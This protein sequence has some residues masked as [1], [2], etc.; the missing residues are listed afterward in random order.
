MDKAGLISHNVFFS[1]KDKSPEAQAHL[2]AA[3]K[4]H[5]TGHPGEVSFAV[6]A[7]AQELDRS[8]NDRD[9]EV[10]LHIVFQTQADHD[11][12]QVAPRHIGF[13]RKNEANWKKVRVFDSVVEQSGPTRR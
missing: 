1:L 4:K 8:V 6:G 3:C 5:L 12:Y 10:S 9:F 2:I 11:R 13:I 7:L